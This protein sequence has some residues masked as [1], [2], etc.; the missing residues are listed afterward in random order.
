[1]KKHSGFKAVAA[2]MEA[3]Q[4]VSKDK[5]GATRHASLSVKKHSPRLKKV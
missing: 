1:M 5:A 4:G 3:K 2:K